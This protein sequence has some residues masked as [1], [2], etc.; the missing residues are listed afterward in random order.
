[1]RIFHDEFLVATAGIFFD[2]KNRVLLFK[3]EFRNGDKWG[4][5]SGYINSKEHPKDALECEVTEESGLVVSVDRKFKIRTD[6]DSARLEIL[7]TGEFIGGEFKES[8]EVA[9]AKLFK[10][11]QLPKI[12]DDIKHFIYQAYEQ[13]ISGK[14]RR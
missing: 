6:R 9:K 14:V 10:T 8:N 12:S 2:N 1:M 5:P 4:I 13:R 3:H 11:D 7:Y